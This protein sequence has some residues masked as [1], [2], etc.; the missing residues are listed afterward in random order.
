MNPKQALELL[1]QIRLKIELNGAD[2]ELARKAYETLR[3]FIEESDA[4]QPL[5]T[6]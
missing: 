3:S 2:H 1:N 5:K 4:A 6:P